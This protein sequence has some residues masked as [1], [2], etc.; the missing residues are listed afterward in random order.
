MDNETADELF[1]RLEEYEGDERFARVD[2]WERLRRSVAPAGETVSMTV[3]TLGFVG[4]I[5]SLVAMLLGKC[6]YVPLVVCVAAWLGPVAFCGNAR[7]DADTKRGVSKADKALGYT[8]SDDDRAWYARYVSL[9]EELDAITRPDKTLAQQ[10]EEDAREAERQE[11][12]RRA[13]QRY[14]ESR[15]AKIDRKNPTICKKCGS[16]DT[17]VLGSGKKVALGRAIVGDLVA[18][19]I[20]AG[21]GAMTGKRNRVEMICRSCGKRWYI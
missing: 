6:D 11:R 3:M 8:V 19:P 15:Q 17:M 18:G 10:R 9:K 20:G 5:V 12:M 13:R 1:A 21:I 4:A 2:R 14:E 16:R 7:A